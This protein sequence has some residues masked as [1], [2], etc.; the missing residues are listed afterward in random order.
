M[1][2]VEHISWAGKLAYC[3]FLCITT[4][5]LNESNIYLELNIVLD[6]KDKHISIKF[7]TIIGNTLH[8]TH[9]SIFVSQHGI[10]VI[11]LSRYEI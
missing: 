5:S 11:R 9:Y 7:V 8:L 2:S 3:M 6:I 10:L 1:R 4:N